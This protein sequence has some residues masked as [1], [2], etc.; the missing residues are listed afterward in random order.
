MSRTKKYEQFFGKKIYNPPEKF[1]YSDSNYIIRAESVFDGD[2]SIQSFSD[3]LLDKSDMDIIKTWIGEN[4]ID[5]DPL[6]WQNLILPI[7]RFYDI[8]K[9]TRL[10]LFQIF[11]EITIDKLNK[12]IKTIKKLEKLIDKDYGCLYSVKNNLVSKGTFYH[13]ARKDFKY[14]MKAGYN[15]FLYPVIKPL[16]EKLQDCGKSIEEQC[17]IV[18]SLYSIANFDKFVNRY[19][20]EENSYDELGRKIRGKKEKHF[21]KINAMIY[22]RNIRNDT[23]KK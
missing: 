13:N 5:G 18:Y 3:R 22:I 4:E 2:I 12:A 14:E 20:N 1:L 6:E 15:K 21:D 7:L 10:K 17:E 23:F 8:D 9:K 11:R 16:F 19:T